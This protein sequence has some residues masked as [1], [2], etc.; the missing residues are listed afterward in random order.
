MKK[1]YV[2]TEDQVNELYNYL[3]KKPMFE[4]E[5]YVTILRKPVKL[6]EQ[7]A[8]KQENAVEQQG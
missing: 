7:T 1:Q 2:Y 6:E 5:K 8:E 4:V 3:M